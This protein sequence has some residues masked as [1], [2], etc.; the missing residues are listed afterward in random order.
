LNNIRDGEE[1]PESWL[2]AIIILMY[3]KGNV[4]HCDNYREM[5]KS[6]EFRLQNLHYLKINCTL[7]TKINVMNKEL[8]KI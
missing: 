2:K 4:K 8:F 6:T 7:V 5:N 3:E 1:P